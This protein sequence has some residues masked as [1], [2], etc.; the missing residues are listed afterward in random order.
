[1][2]L[3]SLVIPGLSIPIK[4]GFPPLSGCFC[5]KKEPLE[6]LGLDY[7]LAIK[8]ESRIMKKVVGRLS[9]FWTKD[10]SFSHMLTAM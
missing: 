1:M 8:F 10:S 3:V 6:M 4:E 5:Q 2:T 9:C 7:L